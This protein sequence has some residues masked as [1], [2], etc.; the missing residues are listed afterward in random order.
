[1][2]TK[3]KEDKQAFFTNLFQTAREASTV[4]KIV[5]MLM[6]MILAFMV[7]VFSVIRYESVIHEFDSWFNFRTTRYLTDKGLYSFWNWYDSES[8]HPLG[9]VIGGT[10]FPGIMVT[11]SMIKWTLDFL[12]F[13]MDIRNICVFLAPVFAGFTSISTYML[14]KECTNR[15]ETGS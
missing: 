9:R 4:F 2:S 7:R 13:P 5:I 8:W 3:N 11:S 15:V 1:M 10:I 12:T 6:I 14:A